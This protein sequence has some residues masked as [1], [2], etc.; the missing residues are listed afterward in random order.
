[1]SIEHFLL[2]WREKKIEP[3]WPDLGLLV[4]CDYLFLA[5][6]QVRYALD[7]SELHVCI[8]C[9]VSAQKPEKSC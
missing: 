4:G 8:D 3:F 9:A 2:K 7:L 5:S 6:K 1:M